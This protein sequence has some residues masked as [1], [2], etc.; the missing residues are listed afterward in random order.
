MKKLLFSL[1]SLMLC[2]AFTSCDKDD[3]SDSPSSSTTSSQKITKPTFDKDLSTADLASFSMKVRFKTGGDE[4]SNLDAVV[5]WKSYMTKP[6]KTPSKSELTKTEYMRQYG[7]ATYHNTGPKK[8]MT[9][10][11][12]FD[13]SHADGHKLYIYFYVECTNSKGS[14]TSPVLS[15]YKRG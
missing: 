9:E 3:D 13:K 1:L 15:L 12:V 11:I 7:G 6:S 2:M 10:S 8:G 4:V 5:H 14:A